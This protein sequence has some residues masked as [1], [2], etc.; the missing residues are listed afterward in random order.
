VCRLSSPPV[1]IR[2]ICTLGSVDSGRRCCFGTRLIAFPSRSLYIFFCSC[3]LKIARPKNIPMQRHTEVPS[4]NNPPIHEWASKYWYTLRCAALQAGMVYI[5]S[6]GGE[7]GDTDAYGAPR[8]VDEEATA[9]KAAGL[10]AWFKGMA[11][12][13]PCAEC[14]DHYIQDWERFPFTTV[15]ATDHVQAIYWLEAL[16]ARIE[17]RKKQERAN[18]KLNS[19]V[20]AR[21][22][23]SH[24]P[25]QH[26]SLT[27]SQIPL[28][29]HTRAHLM[30]IH[31]EGP[32]SNPN[33]DDT[34]DL[35]PEPQTHVSQAP[36]PKHHGFNAR[37]NLQTRLE[38]EDDPLYEGMDSVYEIGDGDEDEDE[39]GGARKSEHV[40]GSTQ[41]HARVTIP[42]PHK[43]PRLPMSTQTQVAPVFTGSQPPQPQPQHSLRPPPPPPHSSRY[44]QVNTLGLGLGT[45]LKAAK[46]AAPTKTTGVGINFRAGAG[47]GT[48]T[49]AGTGGSVGPGASLAAFRNGAA[50]SLAQPRQGFGTMATNTR[51][52]SAFGSG[53]ATAPRHSASANTRGGITTGRAGPAP[54]PALNRVGDTMRKTLAIKSMLQTTSRNNAQ[55]GCV[56]CR[57]RKLKRSTTGARR[58]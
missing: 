23:G 48:G 27:S 9:Q 28:E 34:L 8:V 42:P 29:R 31:E 1:R 24:D 33:H 54:A 5:D 53:P 37:T 13:L 39:Y 56:S 35:D 52:G 20:R 47:V 22:P 16:N 19:R 44:R 3:Y 30:T 55:G 2:S 45:G 58:V 15:H 36:E 40:Q 46:Y 4:S 11:H 14:R 57:D 12:A 41:C 51:A 50:R 32:E 49:G 17:A 26:E 43:Q 10:I 6:E 25:P 7:D 18:G 38:S 21:G